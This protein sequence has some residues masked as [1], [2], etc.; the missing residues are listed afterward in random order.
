MKFP[1]LIVSDLHITEKNLSQFSTFKKQVKD[2]ARLTTRSII[3]VG[4]IFDSPD[5]VKWICAIEFAKFLS[6]LSHLE[7]YMLTGNHDRPLYGQYESTLN[8]FS[9]HGRVFDR[10]VEF[11]GILWLPYTDEE[12]AQRKISESKCV[13]CFL[14]QMIRGL[15][16]N[17]TATA[18]GLDHKIFDKFEF[19]FNG[20]IHQPQVVNSL[21]VV[22]SP[23]Q[24]SFSEAG[25]QK[26]LWFWDGKKA[27]PIKSDVPAQYLI[28][29]FEE[30]SQ[31]DLDRKSVRVLLQPGEDP[32]AIANF[33]ESHGASRWI[34]Q[35]A[36]NSLTPP[37]V[38]NSSIR[39]SLDELLVN[40]AD[41]RDLSPDE[42]SLGL[43]FLEAK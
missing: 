12:S 5:S 16:L 34:L 10:A 17:Q 32:S 11:D 36:Q 3:F 9:N 18:R 42:T 35:H 30:L 15:M 21:Y 22:G 38:G 4:D 14:H 19:A 1:A 6:E 25:Q 37:I 26:Y 40:F 29:T 27:T 2:L 7:I 23:W 33:L 43:H 39:T 20:H 24:H 8:I 13:A 31:Q 41:A 28:G